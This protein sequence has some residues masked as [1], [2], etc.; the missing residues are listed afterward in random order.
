MKSAAFLIINNS[1]MTCVLSFLFYMVRCVLII[2]IITGGVIYEQ[3]LNN[4]K[5]VFDESHVDPVDNLAGDMNLDGEFNVTDLLLFQKWLLGDKS[6]ELKSW[7]AADYTKDEKLDIYD[8]VL[9]RKAI[10]SK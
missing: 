2:I 5:M 6:A 9:M 10:I 3:L 4:A 8:L 7:K 1:F